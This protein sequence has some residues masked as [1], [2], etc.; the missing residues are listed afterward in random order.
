MK[1]VAVFPKKPNSMH[2]AELP[3]P[4]LE[5]VP[6][7]RGVLVK[8]LRVG[9]RRHRQGDQ[10]RR[11]RRRAAGLRFPGHRPRELRPG[12]GGRAERDRVGARRLCRGD[13]APA[14]AQHLRPDRH[15]RHDHRRH[16]L[17][18]RHQ[19]APR[20]PDRVLRGRPRVHRQGPAG[21][22]RTSACC[23]SRRTRGREGHRPGVR[24]PAP[25]AR[26]AAAAR[27]RAGRGHHRPA[28]DAGP[29]PAR[30]R[31]DASSARTPRSRTCNA[32]LVEAIGARYDQHRRTVAGR[33]GRRSTARSTS[34]SRPPA[35]RRSSSRRC[36]RWARTACWCC[37][38]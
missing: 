38:A 31:G 10:R 18:A 37:P 11:V 25:A 19:P 7:G 36:R 30:A 15:L 12:G 13:R 23:W 17:R 21:P 3:E 16:L 2:L 24:D 26:L 6:N 27:R 32:D 4:R 28:G 1:A 35:T 22:A 8:V 34:S 20:L 9:R 29:A 33:R 5:D 14:R